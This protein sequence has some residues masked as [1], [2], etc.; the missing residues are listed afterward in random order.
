MKKNLI[1][2]LITI[3]ILILVLFSA[4]FSYFNTDLNKIDNNFSEIKSEFEVEILVSNLDTPWAIDF[5]PSGNM[6]FTERGGKLSIYD[7]GSKELKVIGN[8]KVSEVS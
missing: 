6:I 1:F 7:F 8:I 2:G 3:L 4:Y 5:L